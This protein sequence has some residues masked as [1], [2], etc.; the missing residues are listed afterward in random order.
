MSNC[1]NSKYK[2]NINIGDHVAQLKSQFLR[3][4]K[5]DSKMEEVMEVAILVTSPSRQKDFAKIIASVNTLQENIVT[6]KYVT[7]IFIEENK[8]LRNSTKGSEM[9][10]KEERGSLTLVAG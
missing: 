7:S 10:A 6:W 3:W 5:M 8:R 4:K 2:V 1:L 9:I